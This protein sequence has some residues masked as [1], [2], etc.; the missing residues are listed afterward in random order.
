MNERGYCIL[1]CRSSGLSEHISNGRVSPPSTLTNNSP[2]QALL[3]LSPATLSQ[4]LSEWEEGAGEGAGELGKF[5][6]VLRVPSL[7]Q[8]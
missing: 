8:D 6:S 1:F 4:S 7:P 3:F 5:R 2:D